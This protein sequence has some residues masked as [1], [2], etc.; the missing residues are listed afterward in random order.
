MTGD[1]L[2]FALRGAELASEAALAEL[3]TGAPMHQYLAAWR[4]REFA[5]KWRLNRAL[6]ALV[7]SGPAIRTAAAVS[8]AFPSAFERLINLAGDV[9]V[10]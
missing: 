4:Q 8:S 3:E 2:R 10:D 7:A 9:R 6:R 1:G 5:T